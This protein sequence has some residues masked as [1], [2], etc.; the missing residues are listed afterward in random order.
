MEKGMSGSSWKR[1]ASARRRARCAVGRGMELMGSTEPLQSPK[2]TG[3]SKSPLERT[4]E[5]SE[6]PVRAGMR[7]RGSGDSIRSEWT[8]EM[9]LGAA[10]AR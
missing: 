2:S 9:G 3:T 6:A 7:S 1:A 5:V 4:E 10:G 8:L